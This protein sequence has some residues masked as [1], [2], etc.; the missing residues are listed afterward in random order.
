MII[1]TRL[2]TRGTQA[3][4]RIRIPA[5]SRQAADQLCGRIRTGGGACIVLKS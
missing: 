5:Q 3:F 1:G 4:Y 2:R